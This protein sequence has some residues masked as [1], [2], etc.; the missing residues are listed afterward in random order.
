M[1]LVSLLLPLA[2]PLVL[3]ACT[4]A[5]PGGE[6]AGPGESPLAS[7]AI[8][9][10][11]L[12]VPGAAPTAEEAPAPAGAADAPGPGPAAEA[13]GEA[14]GE[15]AAAPIDEAAAEGAAGEGAAGEPG[16]AEAAPAPPPE[17][18]SLEAAAC[19]RRG[20]QYANTPSGG[21]FCVRRTRDAGKA[22]SRQSQ[23]ESLCL[24]RSRSCAPITPVFGCND[25]F[26]D[27]GRRVTLCLD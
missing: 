17:L 16:A 5:L 10:T 24:A 8:E 11:A 19:E 21:N 3:A 22:C 26:Q 1:R 6:A 14:T 20:G 9:V 15:A 13:T 23:C 7:E 27:D 4:L 25:I 18:L 2:L 12:P